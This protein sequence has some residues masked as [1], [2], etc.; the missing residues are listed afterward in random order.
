MGS[1]F[2]RSA[3]ALVGRRL[4]VARIA[5]CVFFVLCMAGAGSVSAAVGQQEAPGVELEGPEGAETPGEAEAPPT[6]AERPQPDQP[7]TVRRE[8]PEQRTAT[9]DT[10]E[11]SDGSNAQKIYSSPVNYRTSS[12]AWQ[13]IEDQ[14]V[15]Q[16]DGSWSPQAS[17]VPISLPS[18]LASGAVSVG[19]GERQISFQLQGASS[20]EG[21]PAGAQRFYSGALP[22]TELSYTA[23]PQ[24]LRE[25]L[26]LQS[27]EAPTEYRFSLHLSAG[28]HAVSEPDGRIAIE[29][30]QGEHVYWIA[31]PTVSDSAPDRPFPSHAPVHYELSADGTLLT[32]VL[33]KAWLTDPERVFPVKIDPEVYF[34][35]EDL[36]CPIISNA[37]A[38]TKECGAHLF[39]GPDSATPK[40]VG[41][42]ILH[43]DTSS[44]PRGSE[45]M[46]SSLRMTF[47]WDTTSSS[48]TIEARALSQSFTT[49]ATWNT[50]DGTNAWSTPGGDF[51]KPIAGERLVNHSEIGE[52]LHFGFTPLVEQWV[53]DPSSNHGVLLKAQ[54]ETVSGYDAFAQD[55]NG[56]GAPEPALEVIY[57]PRFGVPPMGQVYQQAVG[58]GS[59]MSVNVANGNLG[60]TSPDVHYATEGY[61][62][63]LGREYNSQD[64][65]LFGNSAFGNW[66][67]NKGDDHKVYPTPWDGSIRFMVPGGGFT[68]F[69]RA[70]WADGQ[71]LAGDQAFTGEAGVNAGLVEHE[72]KTRTMGFPDGVEWKFNN[73]AYGAP[74]EI[75][76]PSGEGNTLSLTY[77]SERLSQLKD[78]HGHTITVTREAGTN[79]V[80]KLKSASGETWKYAYKEGRMITYTNP[81]T[82]KAKYTYYKTGTATG[83]LESIADPSGTWVIAYD[84]QERVASLR[85]L[86]N[87]TIKKA[88]TEDEITTFG[89]E[90]EQTTVTNPEGGKPVYY[91]DAFGNALEDPDLQEGASTFYAGY[92][93][94]TLAAAT[95]DMNLEDHAAVLDAQLDQQLGANYTGEWFEPGPR[96]IKIGRTSEGYEQTIEQDL[97]NLGPADNAEIVSASASWSALEAAATSVEETLSTLI[98]EGLVSLG[99]EASSNSVVV[100]EANSLTS[101]QKAE[102]S[103]AVGTLTVPTHVV[104]ATV[105]GLYSEPTS[106]NVSGCNAPL[107]GGV[108]IFGPTSCSAGFIAN[109]NHGSAKYLF[110]AGHCIA[111]NPAGTWEANDELGSP[112][113]I[114]KAHSYAYGSNKVLEGGYKGDAGIISIEGGYWTKSFVPWVVVYP[115]G[116]AK[117]KFNEQ[118]PIKSASKTG[119]KVNF[120]VCAG[121]IGAE[122]G[123]HEREDCGQVKATKVV[124]T[125]KNGKIKVGPTVKVNF[126]YGSTKNKL[127]GG[128]SGSP[129]YKRNVA[130]GIFTS[131]QDKNKC[132]GYY[133]PINQA[134]KAL[135][136]HVRTP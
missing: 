32:L 125:Y 104:E 41:R 84:S 53:R 43:F 40:N 106:C 85:K 12:G 25:T 13:P 6:M 73:W 49:G 90:T 39:I 111:A 107:R 58:F 71:P 136:V 101:G 42:A 28:L 129:V 122:E 9:S 123:E 105:N 31:A 5:L 67:L 103:S 47:S 134:E 50:Y 3:R 86:V 52:E 8:L 27:A 30:A 24:S 11:L 116:E 48:R 63:E 77:S 98:A 44:I 55:G 29:D 78:T 14:L 126:C 35:T 66:R 1:T 132:Y 2:Q 70:P 18:S 113:P 82:E 110:T 22:A 69:D 112:Q 96:P 59:V 15:Q 94:I 115:S 23:T 51:E 68:R 21:R 81:A 10:Y 127:E 20:A 54:N 37:F 17:P 72:G 76:D 33:D 93:E 60:V 7:V 64:D 83:L 135:H 79:D 92:A 100:E 91:Y 118:Y 80:T 88:G 36:D 74:T 38:S 16:A 62:T 117:T 114:G 99:I 26:T 45:I 57:E 34:F 102:V 95:E 130:Y 121:G 65:L 108:Q 87:G 75:V 46:R 119:A 61:D 124:T 19:A 120:V 56:E 97:D 4:L 128:N 133:Q 131:I 89:Y 109:A